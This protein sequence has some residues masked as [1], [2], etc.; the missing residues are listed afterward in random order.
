MARIKW[1][2]TS[3]FEK[4][5][6]NLIENNEIVFIAFE[7]YIVL[8]R[9]IDTLK[10]LNLNYTTDLCDADSLE[11]NYNDPKNLTL[12]KDEMKKNT[13]DRYYL[14]IR[15]KEKYYTCCNDWAMSRTLKKNSD[16][17]VLVTTMSYA[18]D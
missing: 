18:R 7:Y 15:P 13:N 4:D 16:K 9:L 11:W 17:S 12:L 6:E 14:E 8:M 5:I 2:G 3:S 10:E 1:I